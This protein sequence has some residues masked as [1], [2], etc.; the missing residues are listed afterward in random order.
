MSQK[1]AISK[2]RITGSVYVDED[3]WTRNPDRVMR[4]LCD[5]WRGCFNN[6]RQ[7]RE[8]WGQRHETRDP[9]TQSQY[10]NSEEF[11]KA[12]PTSVIQSMDRLENK[13]WT[14][15]LR[16][17]KTTKSGKSSRFKSVKD[18]LSFRALGSGYTSVR[19]LNRNNGELLITG[20]NPSGKYGPERKLNWSVSIRFKWSQ[21]IK[22]YTSAMVNWSRGT[23]GFVSD[24]DPIQRTDTGSVVGVDVGITHTLT[25]SNGVHY[26]IPRPS[27]SEEK[28]HLSLQ[29]KLARQDRVNEARGGRSAK[30]RSRR[31]RR[32]V[33]EIN[34]L[35]SKQARRRRD[36]VEKVTTQVVRDHDFI[37]LEDL[38]PKRMSSR[39]GAYKRGLNRGI[40]SSCWGMF[41]TRLQQKADLAGVEIKW[42]DPAYTSQSCNECG[43]I[44]RENRESQ[45]V[46]KCIS[47]GYADNADINAARNI[48][49]IGLGQSLGRGGSVRPEMHPG[50]DQAVPGEPSTSTRRAA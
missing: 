25:D 45:A 31:R 2:V 42:V 36:W 19:R 50:A 44:A 17:I 48:L 47:C 41:Q 32:T 40:L 4:W 37:A 3:T 11:R 24:P 1:V 49:D 16:R 28:R 29:R 35:A 20:R 14:A 38:S 43:H 33:D 10:K 18:G 12:L 30:F 46:F 9:L 21:D 8:W 22:P 13:D 23:I 34:R 26:D 5:G 7:R 39:G 27:R 15:S 6:F